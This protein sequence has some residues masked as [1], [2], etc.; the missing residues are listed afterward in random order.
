MA[1]K[2]VTI[3]DNRG[4]Y[5]HNYYNYLTN[6]TISNQYYVEYTLNNSKQ[7]NVLGVLYY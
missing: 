2:I 3:H 1:I 6:I 4:S 5:L 7:A